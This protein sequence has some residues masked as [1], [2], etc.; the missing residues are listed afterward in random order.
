MNEDNNP[1]VEEVPPIPEESPRAPIGNIGEVPIERVQ[2]RRQIQQL[3]RDREDIRLFFGKQIKIFSF[4]AFYHFIW[5]LYIYIYI[6]I[7]CTSSTTKEDAR[8]RR[9]SK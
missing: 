7:D 3:E 9:I 8:D 5:V 6:Y 2:P 4:A 1:N